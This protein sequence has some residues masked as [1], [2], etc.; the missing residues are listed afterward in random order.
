MIP[1]MLDKLKVVLNDVLIYSEAKNTGG[2]SGTS[3]LG[4]LDG[5][6][7]CGMLLDIVELYNRH[8]TNKEIIFRRIYG[9][10]YS[11]DTSAITSGEVPTR[12][13]RVD[14]KVSFSGVEPVLYDDL[15]SVV[16]NDLSSTSTYLKE[17]IDLS[18]VETKVELSAVGNKMIDLQFDLIQ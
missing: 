3:L 12:A 10:E 4:G 18:S 14:K 1:L 16:S 8:L 17:D 13:F 9:A 2:Y 11:M 6:N 7:G 15:Y 5:Y